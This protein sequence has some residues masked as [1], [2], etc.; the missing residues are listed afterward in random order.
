[1]IAHGT[2]LDVSVPPASSFVLD[3]MLGVHS[4]TVA[5]R[6]ANRYPLVPGDAHPLSALAAST[7]A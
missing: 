2:G 1:M 6:A 7:P 3:T 4:A 5:A